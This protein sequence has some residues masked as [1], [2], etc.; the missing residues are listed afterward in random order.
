MVKTS[1]GSKK[2]WLFLILIVA[3]LFT[4][5]GRLNSESTVFAQTVTSINQPARSFYF[6]SLQNN[7][8]PPEFLMEEEETEDDEESDFIKSARISTSS[9]NSVHTPPNFVI[10]AHIEFSQL[11]FC[12]SD[13]SPPFLS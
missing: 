10:F 3:G 12:F 13:N 4:L 7:Y 6:Q 1:S 2:G 11:A 5:V 9:H 8:T